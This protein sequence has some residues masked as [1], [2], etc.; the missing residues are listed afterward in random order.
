[1]NFTYNIKWKGPAKQL[2]YPSNQPHFTKLDTCINVPGKPNPI[3]QWRKQLKPYVNDNVVQSKPTIN[4]LEGATNSTILNSNLCTVYED[5]PILDHCKGIEIDISHNT[6]ATGSFYV[7]RSATT[8][9]NNKFCWNSKQYLQ[10]RCK[11]YEQNQQLGLY[12]DNSK[13]LSGECPNKYVIFKPNNSEFKQ[14][15]G[16]SSS[17]RIAKLRY[18]TIKDSQHKYDRFLANVDNSALLVNKN[19]TVCKKWK[20]RGKRPYT[21]EQY[22]VRSQI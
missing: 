17:S 8:I 1:M 3:K 18:D 13:Y 4:D 19:P 10:S 12:L 20:V 21:G 11:T 15:G 5:L 9:I 6:C 7:R 2:T 16:V 14:Q 22:T